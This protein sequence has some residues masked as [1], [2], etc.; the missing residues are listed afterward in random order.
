MEPTIDPTTAYVITI[1]RKSGP[2]LTKSMGSNDHL[3][4]YETREAAEFALLKLDG[5]WEIHEVLVG[6]SAAA[7]LLTSEEEFVIW[8]ALLAYVHDNHSA[9]DNLDETQGAIAGALY[10]RLLKRVES[11]ED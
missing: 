5:P 2:L 4:L 9:V 8:A 10:E 1:K 6:S 7:D 3:F 11:R